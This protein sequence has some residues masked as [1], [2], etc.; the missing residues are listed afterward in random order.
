[1]ARSY[2]PDSE[3]DA[4][5]VRVMVFVKETVVVGDFVRV[6]VE[7]TVTVAARVSVG[8]GVRV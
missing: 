8:V 2:K 4:L 5:V 1:M 7:E 6:V 3:I